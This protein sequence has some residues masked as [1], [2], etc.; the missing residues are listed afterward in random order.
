MA[1]DGENKTF[2]VSMVPLDSIEEST[3]KE[4]SSEELFNL[5][6]RIS[7]F[8]LLK[9]PVS[10]DQLMVGD[11]EPGELL[12]SL[13]L[14]AK[15]QKDL[16]RTVDKSLAD[17]IKKD[18]ESKVSFEEINELLHM[19]LF[20]L[21]GVMRDE[22]YLQIM[23]R[24]N[25][26][27]DECTTL[28][29]WKMMVCVSGA[30]PPSKGLCPYVTRWLESMIRGESKDGPSSTL[31]CVFRACE[32]NFNV[33][34]ISGPRGYSTCVDDVRFWFSESVSHVPVFGNSLKE[35]Y[36]E[37]GL[38]VEVDGFKIPKLVV[39]LVELIKD[40]NGY[41]KEGVFR[42]S[43]DLQQVFRLKVLLSR[44][45]D[46][47]DCREF[48]DAAVPCSTLKLWMRVLQVP[49]IP[50]N[51]YARVLVARNDQKR[52]AAILEDGVPTENYSVIRFICNFL[53]DLAGEEHRESTKMTLDNFSMIFAPC[54]MRC[55]LSASA[56]E[57]LRRSSEERQALRQI[58][59]HFISIIKNQ[60]KH[61][62]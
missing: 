50:E 4:R 22:I 16:V 25:S 35:I 39:K 55:P 45:P 44:N 60:K 24:I 46:E 43:G 27:K 49:L 10:V 14:A 62:I 1:K 48:K 23:R 47:I 32:C 42:V 3:S 37:P 61:K 13:S 33:L 7:L 51:L 57:V 26:S 54:F 21:K 29:L 9:W 40:L 31:K 36:G 56:L 41:K 53:I 34:K 20:E 15:K 59:D 17:I 52:L 28:S 19:G 18:S 12:E 8:P 6:R 11:A 58:F 5:R 38:I 2:T 30:F